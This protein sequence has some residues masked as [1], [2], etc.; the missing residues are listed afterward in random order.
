MRYSHLILVEL[1]VLGVP[2]TASKADIKKA[3]FQLAKKYHPDQNKVFN[4][5]IVL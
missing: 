3:Y 5:I 4:L 1:Q 2:R